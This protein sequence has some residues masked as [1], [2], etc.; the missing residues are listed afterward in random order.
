[1]RRFIGFLH[2][3]RDYVVLIISIGFSLYFLSSDE[4]SE[5]QIIR[6]KANSFFSVLYR[7][8][9]WVRGINELRTENELLRDK[10]VQLGLLNSTLLKYKY[11]NDRLR[12]MLN[13]RRKSQLSLIPARVVGKGIS[14]MVSSI[15]IDVGRDQGVRKNMSVLS[16]RGVVGKTVSVGNKTS[17]VQIMTDY[18]FRLSVK[19]EESGATGILRWKDQGV[20]EIWE[21]PE[22]VEPRIGERILTSGYSNIFPEDLPVGE[23]IGFVDFPDLL[24]TVVLARAYTDFGVLEHVFVAGKVGG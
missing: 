22:T 12:E 23:V 7:P 6:G 24:E 18:N 2:E 15:S 19:F 10:T 21:V 13:Y 17:T 5:V 14:P 20:F 11:E 3:R 16:I 4:S 9:L 8:I 1:M